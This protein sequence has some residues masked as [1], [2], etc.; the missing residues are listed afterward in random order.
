MPLRTSCLAA[1]IAAALLACGGDATP[2]AADAVTDTAL[3]APP[4]DTAAP[5]PD[6]SV[7]DTAPAA[8]TEAPADT[9][10]PAPATLPDGPDLAR[11]TALVHDLSTDAMAGRLTGA[12]SG[13]RAE[14]FIADFL[15]STGVQV[16]RQ[17]VTFPLFEVGSPAA[18][19]LLDAAGAPLDALSYFTDYREVDFSGSGAVTGPLTFVG[20]GLSD[21]A[22]DDY[23]GLEV[24][25]HVVAVLTGVP[26]G[27]GLDPDEDGRL[28][29]K[30]AAA[31]A[32][33][34]VGV[35]FVPAGD[36]GVRDAESGVESELRATDTAGAFHAELIPSA[37]P[38]A[39]VHDVA[40]ARLLGR[41][42]ASL[43]AD[44]APQPL[45]RQVRL[46]IRGT[47]RAH[48]TCD[49][50]FAVFPG[51]DARVGDEVVILGAHY[52]HLGVG[53]DGAVFNGASDNASGAAV[54][55]E[56]VARLAESPAFAP[57]RTFVV[58]LFCAEEQGLWGSLTYTLY[59]APL[60]P[61]DDT[62]LM[63][64]LDYIGG[65]DGPYLSNVDDNGHLAVFLGDEREA[66][67]RPVVPVDWGGGCA[68]DDCAFSMV[69]GVPAC[70]F[71][72]YDEHHHRPS[73]DFE[74]LDLDTMR[75]VA[76]VVI[77]GA[78]RLVSPKKQLF[79]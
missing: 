5:V 26:R 43:E 28:D 30:I 69:A 18:L 73:D 29:R 65:A 6:A 76:E 66:A 15:A 11:L 27:H 60:F 56:T 41:D 1:A 7:D 31:H 12:P 9:S 35:V 51:R 22:Y 71:I 36:D 72:A 21:A 49:N 67:D 38:V 23:A 8:D 53:A 78:G 42:R 75:R 34:A 39:F 14:Q 4:D 74:H 48:A 3:P 47:A 46:E 58:A 64:Q 70:R 16:E 2:A 32:H 33:G 77:R 17:Q 59:G 10:P 13:E 63:V 45:D 19:E 24:S 25:G 62:R 68:S 79:P 55:L 61:L 37:M 40:T 52:D 54:A 57:A 44:P 50:L 20:Y